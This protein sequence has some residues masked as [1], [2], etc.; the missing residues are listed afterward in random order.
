VHTFSADSGEALQDT[1][2][3]SEWISGLAWRFLMQARKLC[4]WNA[5]IFQIA[6]KLLG[7]WLLLVVVV[8]GGSGYFYFLLHISSSWVPRGRGFPHSPDILQIWGEL[9]M[10]RLKQSYLKL[11][12]I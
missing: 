7:D 3:L 2:V 9:R 11:N 5:Y 8:V 10:G 1:R 4:R 12:S 6:N